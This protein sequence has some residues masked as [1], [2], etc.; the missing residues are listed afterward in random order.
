MICEKITRERKK[1]GWSQEELADKMNLSRQAISK[2]ES[3]QSIPE[4]EN[5]VELSR[6]FGVTTDYLLKEENAEL[7]LQTATGKKDVHQ[8]HEESIQPETVNAYLLRHGKTTRLFTIGVFL[9]IVSPITT[10]ILGGMNGL[11]L[12]SETLAG[13]IG[14]IML[15]SL[16]AIAVALFIYGG[17]NMKRP[18]GE[19]SAD[20]KEVVREEKNIFY[21]VFTK[22]MVIGTVLCIL[23]V[24][25]LTVGAF[26]KN[27]FF[28]ICSVGALLL[29]VAIATL[30]FVSGGMRLSAINQL[31][32]EGE[33]ALEN[34]KANKI[35]EAVSG[36]YWMSAVAVYLAWSFISDN[37]RLTWIIWPIC[38]VIYSAVRML[39]NLICT[40]KADK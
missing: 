4:V 25:P 38:G 3:G 36:V 27:N 10:I 23:S 35:T 6:L 15:F 7:T 26:I 40:K 24:I 33:Y 14:L 19:L 32:K 11:G 29:M 1:K 31:L 13:S 9:C 28:L 8:T 34:E 12:I 5:V 37:W 20:A 16:V 30:F 17:L 39:V 18:T 2:W 21:P 22:R